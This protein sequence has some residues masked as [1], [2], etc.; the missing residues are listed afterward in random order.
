MNT[1]L[2]TITEIKEAYIEIDAET[3]TE[4]KK[5]IEQFYYNDPKKYKTETVEIIIDL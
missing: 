4:A 2:V 1:Y 5:K 3:P